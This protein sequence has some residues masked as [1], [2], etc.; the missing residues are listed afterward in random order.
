MTNEI[1][2]TEDMID[3]RDIIARIAE[4][5]DDED[6]D[7]DETQELEA[8]QALEQEAEDCCE[9]NDGEALIADHHFE[10]H[11]QEL[12][13]DIGAINGAESWPLNHI[14]WEGA[15]RDLKFDY[16]QVDFDGAT[17]WVRSS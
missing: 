14:D 1:S 17:Y 2:N 6:R 13:E 10:K 3:S 12:A 9:W 4:L 5:V 15:C 16:T 7:E 8:L 11:A